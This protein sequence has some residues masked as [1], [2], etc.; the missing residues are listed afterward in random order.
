MTKENTISPGLPV[1][2]GASLSSTGCNFAVHSPEAEQVFLCLFDSDTETQIAEIPMPAKTGDIW[3]VHIEGIKT[4][5][6]YAYR[7]SGINEPEQGLFFDK[8]KLL[9]DPYTKQLN[10]ALEWSHQTY[11]GDSQLM[12][13]KGIVGE[14]TFDWQGIQKPQV[15]LKDTVI[16][17][18]HVKGLTIEHP[19]VPNELKG[20]YVG[21]CH[22]SVVEHL[23]NL[24]VSSIQLLPVFAYMPE[25]FVTQKGLTNY[26]GYNPISFFS[27]EPRYALTDAVVEFKTMVRELHRAGLEVILDVVYN[28]TA[29]AGYDGLTLS[30]RGLDNRSFYSF[31]PNNY[32]HVNYQEPVN[33][34]GCGNSIDLS[35]PYAYQL[36]MDS[37]RYWATDMQ[38]DG[39]R[40]DLAASLCRDP[41]EYSVF[42]GFLRMV[43]QDPILKSVK[44]IAEPW[45]IGMGGYRLGQFP[46]NW[47]E[48]NDKYRDTVRAFWRGDK[49]LAS[50]FATRLLGSRDIF[51]KGKRA[52]HSSVNNVTYHD[53]F[54]LQD[55][56]SF[57]E[58]HNL[59][60]LESN[61]D[62][63]GHNLSSNYGI[64]GPTDDLTIADLRGR[65]KRNL[66]AT[67]MLSQGTPHMLGGDELNRTQHGNNNAYCQDNDISWF[68][69]HVGDTEQDFQLFCQ[70][71]I[72]LRKTSEVLGNIQL[73]DDHY[74]NVCNVKQIHWYLPSGDEKTPDDWHDPDNQAFAI[75]IVGERT[76]DHWLF[77]FNASKKDRT[78]ILPLNQSWKVIVDTRFTHNGRVQQDNV[79]Q[80]YDLID[81]SLCVLSASQAES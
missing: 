27:P 44:L 15:L 39:F 65:Q 33:N 53:G 79:M 20:T 32:G 11:E 17:E 18:A 24:G 73:E 30:F 74:S 55:L 13:P 26:W 47:L 12:I 5:Q 1:P 25:R 72:A 78:F 7:V 43:K 37:L 52:I 2:M 34:S 48:V 19:D 71:L 10:R 69:W 21:V 68:D 14:R 64:E 36:V 3:H 70:Q 56:V 38:V 42:A 59:A 57:D 62:G 61:R 41:Y 50:E 67:L 49:G 77:L 63:H 23:K 35:Q 75:E 28:H 60:N 80:S 6:Y 76:S 16:Y 66:F 51:H 54:T 22:A 31:T 46:S 29:E 81:R 9:I 40:F 8:D 45:D 58:R 4:K